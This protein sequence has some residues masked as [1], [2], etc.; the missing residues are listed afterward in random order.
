MVATAWV[1]FDDH[2]SL[3]SGETGGKAALP[4]WLGFMRAA[5]DGKPARDFEV[6]PGVQ[7]VRVDPSSGLLAGAHVPGPDRALPRGHR[8]HRR[9]AARRVRRVRTVSSWRSP[10]GIACERG[11]DARRRAPRRRSR[12]AGGARRGRSAPSKALRPARLE[13]LGRVRAARPERPAAVAVSA[14]VTRPRDAVPHS[15][16]PAERLEGFPPSSSRGGGARFP[17]A[18][19]QG[20]ATL[21]RLVVQARPR[22]THARPASCTERAAELLGRADTRLLRTR[23][24]VAASVPPTTAPR[25]LATAGQGA[26]ALALHPTP[27]AR[28]GERTAAIAAGTSMATAS[29]EVAVLL[30]S[31]VQLLDDAGRLLARYS[32]GR[33]AAC[34]GAGA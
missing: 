29:M 28:F 19:A 9:G 20:A 33:A 23:R 26:V 32:T 25:P 6:P 24:G 16:S 1:G 17:A 5:L 4:I 8:A 10:A 14:P 30:E 12:P 2:A 21:V 3:G 27:F 13:A 7:S 22:D 31:E 34:A 15:S 18:Q 11:P